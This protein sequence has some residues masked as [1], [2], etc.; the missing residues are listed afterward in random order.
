MQIFRRNYECKYLRSILC[1]LVISLFAPFNL[2]PCSFNLSVMDLNQ[3]V[4]PG[5]ISLYLIIISIGREE[6]Q[7]CQDER[8]HQL[9]KH[10]GNTMENDP[11]AEVEVDSYYQ[12]CG[13]LENMF[14]ESGS[15]Q[16]ILSYHLP[17]FCHSGLIQMAAGEQS[18]AGGAMELEYDT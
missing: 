15:G 14:L 2:I 12:I 8:E 6:S 18:N 11:H 9:H 1:N 17:G 7:Q 13:Q 10:P 3:L 16:L 5:T 4:K